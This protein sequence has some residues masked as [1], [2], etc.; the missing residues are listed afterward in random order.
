MGILRRIFSPVQ[1]STE[2]LALSGRSSGGVAASWRFSITAYDVVSVVLGALLITAAVAKSL[3]P[4]PDLFLASPRFAI[5]LQALEIAVEVFIG[6]WLV[7]HIWRGKAWWAATLLFLV[8]AGVS[9]W[10]VL[11]GVANC[12]CFGAAVKLSPWYSLAIS[13]AAVGLLLLVEPSGSNRAQRASNALRL[14]IASPFFVSLAAWTAFLTSANW[15]TLLQAGDQ[16]IADG[17]PVLLDP[18]SWV[19]QRFPLLAYIDRGRM[20][21][22]GEWFVVLYHHECRKCCELISHIDGQLRA[23]GRLR[24][25][26]ALV[27][28]PPYRLASAFGGAP[29]DQVMQAYLRSGPIWH[30]QTPALLLL[31]QGQ[32]VSIAGEVDLFEPGGL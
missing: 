11:A 7:S 12:G 6:V 24:Q 17:K 20:L 5:W 29:R 2:P 4:A 26:L 31:N 15:P 18:A 8:L 13:L 22:E 32:V 23:G 19:G 9:F 10:K 30:I 27:Q 28:I 25:P 16:P 21:A 14:A 1:P 3:W